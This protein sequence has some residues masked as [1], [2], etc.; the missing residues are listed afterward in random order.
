MWD[1]RTPIGYFFLLL[2]LI[3]V[4]VSFTNPTAPLTNANVDLI[5]GVIMLAFGGGMR[6]LASR[7]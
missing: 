5:V 7:A 2:G 6:W 1:L 3:L 4:G